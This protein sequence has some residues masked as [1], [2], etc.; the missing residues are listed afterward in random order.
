M[1]NGLQRYLTCLRRIFSAELVSTDF[2]LPLSIRF[3]RIFDREH[4][5]LILYRV[6][7]E[8]HKSSLYTSL[9]L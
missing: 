8:V 7:M 1:R 5:F 9:S 6:P 2:G 4:H 3:L